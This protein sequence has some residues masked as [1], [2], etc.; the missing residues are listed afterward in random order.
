QVQKAPNATALVC[1]AETLSYAELNRRANRLAHELIAQGVIPEQRVA[2]CV[3]RS[4]SMMIGL[5]AI[6]KAG[7]AYVPLDPAYSS[8]RLR[9]ILSDAT[10]VM[11]VADAVGRT[12]LGQDVLKGLKVLEPDTDW[13]QPDSNPQ[14]LSLHSRQLAYVIYTSGTTGVPKGVMVEHRGVINLAID[15]ID[16]LGVKPDSRVLQFASIS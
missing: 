11:V 9:G 10:P 8:D 2:L 5:L 6:L 7:G 16:R 13:E 4:A 3:S 14:G 1:G 12:A 15:H